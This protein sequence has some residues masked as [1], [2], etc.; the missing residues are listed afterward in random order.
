[1]IL[2]AGCLA[3]LLSATT[4]AAQPTATFVK[5]VFYDDPKCT[6]L[7]HVEFE[8]TK[9]DP[10]QRY[11]STT[12]CKE[13][14]AGIFYKITALDLAYRQ[15]GDR[16]AQLMVEF[17]SNSQKCEPDHIE[18]VKAYPPGFDGGKNSDWTEWTSTCVRQ[19]SGSLQIL[20]KGEVT[21]KHET[22]GWYHPKFDV[23]VDPS[24]NDCSGKSLQLLYKGDETC[25]ALGTTGSYYGRRIDETA[26]DQLSAGSKH[27]VSYMWVAL[28]TAVLL[29]HIVVD[30]R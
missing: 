26:Y 23:N 8:I 7:T 25:H 27:G 16:G 19:V 9:D 3:I 17:F 4:K 28:G 20:N 30:F 1:M 2:L 13:V 12:E 6:K 21:G 14:K 29:N 24:T 15:L 10:G 5:K 18:M 11:K 22:K